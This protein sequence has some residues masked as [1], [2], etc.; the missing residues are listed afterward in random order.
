MGVQ[1]GTGNGK[2]YYDT[3]DKEEKREKRKLSD[4]IRSL[5]SALSS[6]LL[7]LMANAGSSIRIL[8]I[9]AGDSLYPALIA[10]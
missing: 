3:R 1:L 8:A 9:H 5:V 6:V 7:V 10:R 4:Q 2:R